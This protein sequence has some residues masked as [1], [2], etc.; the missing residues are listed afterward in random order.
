MLKAWKEMEEKA[1]QCAQVG[2]IKASLWRRPGQELTVVCAT[3]LSPQ[4]VSY[5]ACCGNENI[6]AGAWKK[7]QSPVTRLFESSDLNKTNTNVARL[8][9]LYRKVDYRDT[10]FAVQN[11]W[12]CYRRGSSWLDLLHTKISIAK[13]ENNTN[14]LLCSDFKIAVLHLGVQALICIFTC[15]IPEICF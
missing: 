10:L 14:H 1:S 12:C 6:I 11:N 2:D 9:C 13:A 5:P 8:S 15:R 3:V 4:C 7:K